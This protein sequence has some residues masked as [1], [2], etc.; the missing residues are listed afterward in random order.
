LEPEQEKSVEKVDQMRYFSCFLS[1]LAIDE[2][3]LQQMALVSQ[4]FL[5]A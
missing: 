5:H 4:Y 3:L 1:A 2:T